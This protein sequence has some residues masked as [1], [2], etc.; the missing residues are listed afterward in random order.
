MSPEERLE[1]VILLMLSDSPAP[2]EFQA[3]FPTGG[4]DGMHLRVLRKGEAL[5]YRGMPLTRLFLLLS[6]SCRAMNYSYE[7]KRILTGTVSH[8]QIFGLYELMNDIPEH[9]VMLECTT[10]C[11]ILEVRADRA[12]TCLKTRPAAAFG[13]LRFLA[14]FTSDLISRGN[15]LTM[16]SER[17]NLLLYFYTACRGKPLPVRLSIK[18]EE[19]AELLNLN[20]RTLYRRLD[21]L[22]DERLLLRR[23]GKIEIDAP[24][25]ARIWEEISELVEP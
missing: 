9:S 24:C 20:L 14:M 16:N 22:E 4:E 19:L 11:L 3:L 6:G 17:E 1:A 12:L 2:E 5:V 13:A 23:G 21:S 25:Y 18:K 10:N 7:G 8:P 15:R